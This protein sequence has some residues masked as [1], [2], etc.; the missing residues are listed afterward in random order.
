MISTSR[1]GVA[2]TVR[3][4]TVQCG[5]GCEDKTIV[6]ENL[7][8]EGGDTAEERGAVEEGSSAA[9][10]FLCPSGGDFVITQG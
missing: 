4:H 8:A 1:R 2:L 10:A 7:V 6:E 9:S 5:S 3:T